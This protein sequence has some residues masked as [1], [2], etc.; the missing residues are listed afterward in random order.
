VKKTAAVPAFFTI[1]VAALAAGA[2]L[3]NQDQNRPVRSADA[4]PPPARVETE[5]R[6]VA[7]VPRPA[8]PAATTAAH[9]ARSVTA[10]RVVPDNDGAHL[11]PVK[12]AVPPGKDPKM[13]AIDAM[14]RLKD[15]PLPPGTQVRSVDMIG[16]GVATVDFNKAFQSNF[17]GG[18]QEE[19]LAINA[20]LATLAQFE[21][22][23]Q[24]QILVEG[25]KIDSLGG[26]QSLAEP[27][28]VPHE[29][30]GRPT[31]AAA[32]AAARPPRAASV[33]DDGGDTAAGPIG[34]L[35]FRARRPVGRARDA[36]A[37]ARRARSLRRRHRA[38]PVRRAGRWTRCAASR[39]RSPA[40]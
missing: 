18:D 33:R 7:P 30:N 13:A 9:P 20:V 19:A 32:G 27:L 37:A 8:A 10:Y 31:T 40:S 3:L 29:E 26:T 1:A 17:P 28:P 35:R 4:L 24:V 15:S 21:G 6:I 34:G 36:A 14:A 11:E 16:D 5:P 22:V 38:R 12:A 25:R 2:Y 23:E 39:P